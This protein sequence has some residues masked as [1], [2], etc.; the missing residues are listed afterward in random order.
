MV[1]STIPSNGIV[2]IYFPPEVTVPDFATAAG[3]CS[4]PSIPDRQIKCTFSNQP[5]TVVDAQGIT[6]TTTATTL[7]VE[8]V[9][10]TGLRSQD[11]FEIEI[12]TGV[13]TPMSLKTSGTFIVQVL[14]SSFF[15]VNYINTAL[16][17]T[18]STGI[19]I[20]PLDF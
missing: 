7:V 3:A 1:A 20:G 14:D 11:D 8:Q 5:L 13:M 9:F 15:V 10:G 6:Q 2:R 18:M 16:L 19:D 12:R 4:M 17:L